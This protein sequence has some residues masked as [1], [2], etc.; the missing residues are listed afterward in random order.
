[1]SSPIT[2]PTNVHVSLQVAVPR[3]HPR[4]AASAEYAA[5]GAEWGGLPEES[6]GSLSGGVWSRVSHLLQEF[7]ENHTSK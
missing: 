7:H 1:M 6:T 5:V 2:T 4:G 3:P